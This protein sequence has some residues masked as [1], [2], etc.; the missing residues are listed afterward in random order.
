M[1]DPVLRRW[2][3]PG[4]NRAGRILA[5]RGLRA[6]QITGAGLV[7]GLTGA[8]VLGLGGPGGVALAFMALG[9]LAD[10]LD[11]AVA[12]ATGRAEDRG[13]GGYLDILCD[14]AV[15]AAYPL[16]FVLRDAGNGAAGAFLLAAF[17]INGASFLGYALL[18]EKTGLR[19]DAR[20]RKALYY[21]A[22][23]LEGGETIAFFALICL[24]PQ[25]F[26]AMATVFGALCVATTVARVAQAWRVFGRAD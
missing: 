13:F 15:Y 14:F 16:A 23:L 21:S 26:A 2:M 22:G 25:H 8:V 3:D 19:T 11:G 7:L 9:R 20:G 18:A 12:R 24:W 10:G 17:Y 1:F 5:A 6:N 4:L